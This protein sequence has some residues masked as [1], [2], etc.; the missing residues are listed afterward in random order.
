MIKVGPGAKGREPSCNLRKRGVQGTVAGQ[1]QFTAT[2]TSQRPE[3]M[4]M[5]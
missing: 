4:P 3:R 5:R 2:T 1:S